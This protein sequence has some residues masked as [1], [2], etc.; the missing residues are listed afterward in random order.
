MT[1]THENALIKMQTDRT[2]SID[3]NDY[4]DDGD[5]GAHNV[6]PLVISSSSVTGT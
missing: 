1:H 2:S 4:G 3:D 5:N 6:F